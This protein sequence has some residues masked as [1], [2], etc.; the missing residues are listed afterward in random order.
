MSGEVLM[1]RRAQ[2]ALA[3]IAQPGRDRIISAIRNLSENPRPPGVKKLAGR[4][5]FFMDLAGVSFR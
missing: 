4:T 2:R 5:H 3:K 1:E